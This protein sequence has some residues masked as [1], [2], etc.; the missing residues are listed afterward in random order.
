MTT[1]D[2]TGRI[3]EREIEIDAPVA[4]V[5]TALT[6]ADELMRWFPP[7]A[8][9]IPGVGGSIWMRWDDVYEG[10]S[11]IEAWE[12]EHHLRTLFPKKGTARL[13]TDYY[14]EGEGGKTVLRVVTSGFGEGAEWDDQ[15]TGVFFGWRFEL[16]SLRHY[17]ERHLGRNRHV[18][19][20]R[21]PYTGGFDGAW[22][23]LME[24]M[25]LGAADELTVG[26]TYA[27]QTA[28]GEAL[29]GGVLLWHP[30]RQFVGTVDALGDA[31]LRIETKGG[32]DSGSAQIW[33]S[34]YRLPEPDVRAL[35][36]R[37]QSALD[38]RFD[39]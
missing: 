7:E 4:T 18:A 1:N 35:E 21:A 10:E 8:K 28:T 34:S 23:H 38:A 13:A 12:P 14:L 20:A 29:S 9:S 24:V 3:V 32:A 31:L 16:E 6:E 5:W 39:G 37:W 2:P 25:G 36:A 30:P 17:L 33:L 26:G 15:Y 27:A 11:E 19:W 22:T